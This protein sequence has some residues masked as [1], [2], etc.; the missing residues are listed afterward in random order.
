MQVHWGQVLSNI[1]GIVITG[2]VLSCVADSRP[3]ATSA[4]CKKAECFDN[5]CSHAKQ[6]YLDAI[7]RFNTCNIDVNRINMCSRK[8]HINTYQT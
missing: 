8:L 5:D 7:I 1:C 2:S 6:V 4:L 3:R